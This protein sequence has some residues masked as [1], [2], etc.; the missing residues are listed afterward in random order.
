MYLKN[1]ISE[2]TGASF[3]P[4]GL[5]VIRDEAGHALHV[6]AMVQ[7]ITERKRTEE[8]LQLAKYTVDHA[9]EAIYW[10]GSNAE[11]LDVNDA[12]T[13]MLGYSRE[14][15]LGMTV[16]DLNSDFPTETWP[17]YWEETRLRGTCRLRVV[18]APGRPAHSDRSRCEFHVL[19]RTGMPLR[20]RS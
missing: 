3:G 17:S 5:S 2:K 8:A 4:V 14:E 16:H 15:L 13:V 10:V 11:L 9:T 1:G 18:I 6:L 7:D 19:Q 12:A 20:L